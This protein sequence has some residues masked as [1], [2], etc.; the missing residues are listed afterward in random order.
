MIGVRPVG[1]P[2]AAITKFG[3]QLS[4]ERY[5]IGIR[6]ALARNAVRAADFHPNVL[7][8]K[9]GKKRAKM[10]MIETKRGIDAAH[11]IDNDWDG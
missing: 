9:Q 11:V 7:V 4:G 3:H 10:R 5:C 6:W 1:A 2:D 8:I